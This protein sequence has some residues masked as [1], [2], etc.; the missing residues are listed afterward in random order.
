M[1]NSFLFLIS[2]CLLISLGLTGCSRVG[3]SLNGSGKIIDQPIKIT[4][5]TKVSAKGAFPVEITQA[6][7]SS[8]TVSTDDNLINR[9]MVALD[10][11]TLLLSIKAPGS[12]LPTS[13]KIQINMPRI[14]GLILSD[15]TESRLS[16]FKSTYNFSLDMQGESSLDGYLDAGNLDF[17]VNEGSRVNLQG[18]CLSLD[19]E[20][21]KVSQLDLSAFVANSATI[22]LAEASEAT[23]NVVGRLT[24]D[25][26]GASKLYYFG[27]PVLG[28]TS[29]SSG[30]IM[31]PR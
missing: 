21:S 31:Q 27:N 9:V 2:F 15:G 11:E 22:R 24:T 20:A 13:L 16:G 17:S 28:I 29:I 18:S 30:S 3:S 14:Y 8:V 5:F 6:D 26:E 25:L 7:I 10:D 1:K 4:G 23:V 12:F 19:L